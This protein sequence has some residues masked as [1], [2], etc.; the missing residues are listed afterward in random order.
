M[1]KK[2]LSILFLAS[3]FFLNSVEGFGQECTDGPNSNTSLSISLQG[4]SSICSDETISFTS[5]PNLDGAVNATYQ[6]Q[7]KIGSGNWQDISGATGQSLNNYSPQNNSRFRLKMIFCAGT[8]DETFKESNISATI[9][10]NTVQTPTV[11]ITP[12]KT[13]ICPGENISFSA[14]G[15]NQGT[16]T[17]EW[18]IN[19]TSVQQGSSFTLNNP[20]G[21][22]QGDNIVKVVMTSSLSCVTSETAN[23]E[24]IYTIKPIATISATTSTE[25]ESCINT[26][27]TPIKFDIGGGGTGATVSSL[28]PGVSGSFSGGVYTLSGSPTSA[29]TFNYTVNTTGTCEQTSATGSITV[30]PNATLSLTSG[31]NNQTVCAAGGVG[32]SSINPITYSIGETGSDGTVANLPSGI[33]GSYSNGIL[34]ISGSSS[35]VGT[36]NFTVTATGDCGNSSALTGSITITGNLAPLVSITSSEDDNE[37]CEGAPVTFTATP[38][39]G[40]SSPSYQWKVDGSDVGTNS[41]I[42]TTSSL[43][44]DQIVTVVMTSN[45]T[46][47]TVNTAN[48]TGISTKVNPNL[49]PSV[50]IDPSDTNFCAGEEVTYTAVPVN[51]GLSPTYQWKVGSTVVGSGDTF[52]S[53]TLT[54]EQSITVTITSSETCVTSSTAVSE[55]VVTSV[56]ENLVPSVTIVSN[57]EN[58]ILCSGSNIAFTATPTNG[59]S[60]PQYQWQINGASSGGVTTSTIF[61]SSNLNNGDKVTAVLISNEECLAENN[62]ISNEIAVQVDNSIGGIVPN[63]DYSITTHNPTAICPVVSGLVYKINEIEGATSYDWTF[64][65]GWTITGGTGTNE[66]KLTAGVSAAAGKITVKGRNECGASGVAELEVTTGTVV[67]VEA[68]PDA[69]LCPGTT[70]LNLLGD[71]GG[72]ITKSQDWDWFASVNGGP[73]TQTGFSNGGNSLE[74]TYSIPTSVQNGGTVIIRIQSVKPAGTCDIKTDDRVITI[75]SAA[76]ITDASNKNQTVCLNSPINNISFTI[77]GA[78]KGGTA[79]G[80][81]AGVSGNFEGGIFTLSGT[82]TEAGT[83]NYTVTTTGNCTNAN[84]TGTLTVNPRPT[85][86]DPQDVFVCAGSDT[87]VVTFGGS[88]VTGTTYQWTNDNTSIGL[89]ASGTGSINGFTAINTTNAPLVANINVTPIANNCEGTAQEFQ[90]TVYPTATFTLPEDLTVCNGENASEIVFSGSTVSGTSYKWSNSNPSIG[91]AAEGTG[92]IS[93]FSAVNTTNAPVDATITVTPVANGCDGTPEEFT[94]TVNPTPTFTTPENIVVCNGEIIPQLDFTGATVTGTTY[95]WTNSN[96]AIGLAA[97][98]IETGFLPSFSAVNNGNEPVNAT[99]TVT[100]TANDCAGEPVTFEITVH[101]TAEVNNVDDVVICNGEDSSEIVLSSTVTGTSF[102]WTNSNPAIG[103]AASGNGNIPVFTAENTTEQATTATITITP[104]ANDCEGTPYSFEITV[105]PSAIVNAGD[106][107][108]ICSNGVATMA[109]SFSG[110]A[111][112]GTWT[113]SGSGTFNNNTISAQ[114]T[115]SDSDV[116]N[117]AVIL[118]YTSNDPDG[119]CGTASD[120]MELFINEEVKITTQPENIG[121]CSTEPSQLTVIASGDNLSYEWKRTDGKNITNSNGI[122]S[123]TLSFNNTTSIN[124]GE[125]YVVVKGEDVCNDDLNPVE[126][127]RVTINVDENIIIDEPTKEIPICGD[128]FSVANMKVIAHAGDS[129]LSFTWYKDGVPVDESDTK[130]TITGPTLI[131]G[132]YHGT[133]EINGVTVDNNGDYYVE[134][135]GPE[136]F[137]CSIAVTNPFQLRLAPLPESPEVE[138]LMVCQNETPDTFT[139]NRGTNLLWYLNENDENYIVNNAGQP[140]EPVPPTDTSGDFYY[141][142]SQTPDDC[143]SPRVQVKVTVKEKPAVPALTSEEAVIEYCSGE[144]AVSLTATVIE[145]SSLNWYDSETGEALTSAPTPNTENSGETKYW[146]S[147][148]PN[149]GSGCESDRAEITVTVFALPEVTASVEESVI[150]LGSPAELTASGGVSYIWYDGEDVIG[151]EASILHPTTAAGDYTFTVVATNANGCKNS[152]EVNVKVDEN[153]VA[154]N[155][156]GQESVCISSPSGSFTLE[157]YTGEIQRWESSIDGGTN[158]TEIVNN[159]ASFNFTALTATTSFR[160]IVKSGVCDEMATNEIEVKIDPLPVGGEL[161][162]SGNGRVFTICENPVG[163]YAVDLNLTGVV[164]EVVRWGYRSWDATGYTTLNIAGEVF[165]GNTLTASQIQ[166]L[167]FNETTVFQVEVTSGV[168]AAPALSKTAILSVIPSDITPTPVNVDPG[169]VCIGEEVTLSSET[170]YQ[171]GGTILDQGAFDNASITNHGWRIR[172]DGISGDLGFDTDANNTEFDRWKRATPRAFTTAS[173]NSPYGTSGVLFDTGINDG[174]K[175]FALISG[176]YKSTMETPVFTIGSMDQAVL[177]FDQAYVLT[178]GASIKVEIST[179]GGNTYTTLYLREV[180]VN[181]SIGIQSGNT[182]SFG[183]GTVDTRP[184]NKIEIDLGDYIGRPNLRIRFNYVGARPGDIWAVDNIDIPEG[185]NGITMEWR[186]YTDPAFPEGILIGT[187]NSENYTPTEIGLNTFEVKTKLVYNSSGDACEVA[188]NAQRIE[189]FVFDKYTTSVTASYGTCGNFNV[190]LTANVLDGKGEPVTSFPTLDGY[191]GKWEIVGD[192]TLVDSNTTDEIAAINDP[193]AILSAAGTGSY[194]VS[195]ILEPTELDEN[196]D[197]YINPEACP[198]IVTP[199]DVTIEGCIALDFDGFNDYVDLETNYTGSNYSIEAWIRPFDRGLEAG[200]Q[201]DATK[202]TIISGAGFEIKMEDLPNSITPNGRWYHIAYTSDKK[203]F[204]DGILQASNTVSGVGGSHTLIGARWNSSKKEAENYFS[205]WIE[206]VRIWNGTITE[207]NIQFTMNQRLKSTGNIGA[208]VNMDHPD[209]PDYANL[210]GYYQLISAVPDPAGLVTYEDAL[211]PINGFTIDLAETPIP[212]RLINMSTNQENTAPLPY[213]SGS[214]GAWDTAA[215]WARPDVWKIPNTGGINWN[216]VKT[217]HNITAVRDITVLGLLSEVNTLDMIG[218]NPTGWVGG[219][220]GYELFISHYLLLNGVIDLNGE[221]QLRQ[222]EGSIVDGSSGGSLYRDQ[223]GTANSYNYNYWSS[224]VSVDAKNSPYTVADVLRDGTDKAANPP[225]TIDFGDPYGYADGTYTGAK[226]ISNYWISIFRNNV[227]DEYGE[228]EFQY[229][230]N[231][232]IVVGE[233]YTMKGTSGAVALATAQN[234]TFLGLPNNGLIELWSDVD[235]NYLL[236]NPYPSALDSHEFIDDNLAPR[237]DANHFDGSLYFWD[238]FGKV[239]SHILL[240]YVGGYATLNKTGAVPAISKD[241]RIDNSNTFEN[242]AN[243]KI[244]GRYIPVGQA[245]FINSTTG[246]GYTISAGDIQFK[247]S[248]RKFIT[249]KNQGNSQFLKP[250]IQ[251]KNSREKEIEKIRISYTSP[252]GYYRQILVGAHPNA[253][254]GFDLGYDA[255][256]FDYNDEDM[257]WLQGENWLVIQ[258]VP[259]FNKERVLPLGIVVKEEGEFTIKIDSLENFTD[260]KNVYIN[261]KLNDTVHNLTKSDYTATSKGGYIHDRFEIIFYYQDELPVDPGGGEKDYGIVLR[262]R[263]SYSNRQIQIWNPE[264]IE[265][266]NLYLFDLNGNMLEDYD[267][268]TNEKEIILPVRGYSSG[269]YILKLYAKDKVISKKIIISN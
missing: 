29:G 70:T 32:D 177:T 225:T 190:Q 94:I 116:L 27:I 213:F 89:A 72:V 233:G 53:S 31:N 181:G 25:T 156:S 187:N 162:F 90:I 133:L 194:T 66:I 140:T 114:Y 236:G 126:S 193:N 242:R 12:T 82:P 264:Q 166:A 199:L 9:T 83:F 195:W 127:V 256:I 57:D 52:T 128:G 22:N 143:E 2:L 205:G 145:G 209:A 132:K 212:G 149:D 172:R 46:C 39:N 119:P 121:I 108:T 151:N 192:A 97:S 88:S 76:S 248:Q 35:A 14:N 180:P 124:A 191:I 227:A 15:T 200:G 254:D 13:T 135:N 122:Y 186:D 50:T 64:P 211:K 182:T 221:S 244:P 10:V 146:V 51:G 54:N 104:T 96:T 165:S 123:S 43:M 37:I 214:N 176:N 58:N 24:I 152:A 75:L 260:V 113:T 267:Q 131:E 147:Q 230:S 105:N 228:W 163:N 99:I 232:P 87:S 246:A 34:T 19:G 42:F 109:A 218:T 252:L 231:N 196:G 40:G 80:L 249:E 168:C 136:E 240:E 41:N 161:N 150:C 138:D 207:K 33:T 237:R 55:P 112:E 60:N 258:G 11:N 160:A 30:N 217:S 91:L 5:N 59:G 268:I 74:G 234:Y 269:V 250:E 247:N 20:S 71:I 171:I 1:E 259:D 198:P 188:E 153:T 129:P 204:I 106:D 101:P 223:Q 164:G 3:L 73:F 184:E 243:K 62:V 61:N 219:G 65:T 45:E 245:F 134:I 202:G 141:W 265:I 203:L 239:D 44:D 189:V 174:N 56:N 63:W 179:D 69:E 68:G 210:A 16:P 208:V 49:E 201:T 229:G 77:G 137:T 142:V 226:K 86:T 18:F 118:T 107:Q 185:P 261:D 159:S 17:Y 148:T 6:W 28:P 238:H 4:S 81:P 95:N 178:P 139:V 215:T 23:K 173:I 157:G 7:E 144:T 255:R 21:L 130:I 8:G 120:T 224:P 38:T 257:Y 100:P 78:G 235:R 92:N 36:H 175:G 84:R 102:T 167:G 263:H 158:W 155:I 251:T 170:G 115:P 98:G 117:G 111:T 67:Y 262:V 47:R 183:T 222:P 169:V 197:L 93:S 220:S 85:F 125:Y 206:E 216:I 241:D 266:S 154:G 103:L 26:A 110:G 48:S 253:T 79:S